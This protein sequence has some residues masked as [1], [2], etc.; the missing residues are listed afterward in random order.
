MMRKPCRVL[1][2]TPDAGLVRAVSDTGLEA[3]ALRRT[4]AGTSYGEDGGVPPERTLT[5]GEDP[6]RTLRELAA[7]ERAVHGFDFVLCGGDAEPAVLDVLRD[8]VP[9][10]ERT[11][12]WPPDRAELRRL[13][14]EGPARRPS[15]AGDDQA[16]VC[17]VD[18]VSVAGM[19]LLLDITWPESPVP[20]G[21]SVRV[22]VRETVRALLD[23]VGHE[24]G[25]MRTSVALTALGPRPLEMSGTPFLVASLG[26]GTTR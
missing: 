4:G 8:L 13:L 19:H 20:F 11:G 5:A 18:T 7:D 2:L 14:D 1:L 10:P 25:G 6:A 3:W 24:S 16:P 17:H 12:T 21:E 15:P 9:A 26:P 22:G 23:L